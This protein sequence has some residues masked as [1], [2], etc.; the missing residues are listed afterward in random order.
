M[1][2]V[3][4]GALSCSVTVGADGSF[5]FTGMFPDAQSGMVNLQIL[6]ANGNVVSESSYLI[7]VTQ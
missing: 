6:D 3:F 1:T 2:A 5:S 4:S 7:T